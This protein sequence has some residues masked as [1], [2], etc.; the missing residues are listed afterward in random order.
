MEN[1]VLES[2]DEIIKAHRAN[3]PIEIP[4]ELFLKAVTLAVA[5]PIRS[6]LDIGKKAMEDG[7]F[8]SHPALTVLNEWWELNRPLGEVVPAGYVL[9]FVRN[10]NFYE[11]D[12][13]S[14]KNA[15]WVK[16]FNKT[17]KNC[18]RIGDHCLLVFIAC[19][20]SLCQSK[21]NLYHPD[22]TLF[23]RKQVD[24]SYAPFLESQRALEFLQQ[25]PS[26]FKETWS[27]LNKECHPDLD[28]AVEDYEAWFKHNT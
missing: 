18:A 3:G 23:K 1:E 17:G 12:A 6:Q 8:G 28:Y 22:E 15:V 11:G 14:F 13:D 2:T 21:V 26:R 7:T 16:G 19:A 4:T 25:F 9:T 10:S 27:K 24:E 20:Y 5:F